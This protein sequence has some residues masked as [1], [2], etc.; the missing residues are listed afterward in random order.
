MAYFTIQ[1]GYFFLCSDIPS[2]EK[3]KLNAFLLVLEESDC[4]CQ[5]LQN[6]KSRKSRRGTVVFRRKATVERRNRRQAE[7]HATSVLMLNLISFL[8][9]LSSSIFR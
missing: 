2:E 6:E 7:R 4:V 3:Q 9:S 5:V 8:F 1:Q